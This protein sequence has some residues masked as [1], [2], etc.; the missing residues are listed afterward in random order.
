MS[1]LYFQLSLLVS[2]HVPEPDAAH[3]QGQRHSGSHA[4]RQTHKMPDSSN[5]VA[6][7]PPPALLNPSPKLLGCVSVTAH[8][9]RE[10]KP[11]EQ[12]AP[13]VLPSCVTPSACMHP[14]SVWSTIWLFVTRLTSSRMSISPP[15]GQFGARVQNAGHTE[16]PKG[17][18]TASKMITLPTP[19]KSC[20]LSEI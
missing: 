6:H 8:P 13:L 11:A 10:F 1:A 5:C 7:T 17:K 20:V 4:L 14:G 9:V 18:C 3:T 15:C 19:K 2:T 16:H 12:S